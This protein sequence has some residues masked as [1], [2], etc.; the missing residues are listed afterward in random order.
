MPDAVSLPEETQCGE[1]N[2]VV[3]P[4]P[5][6]LMQTPEQRARQQIEA[7]LRAA[8]WTIQDVSA[9]NLTAGRGIAVREFPL[10]RGHGFA[11]YLL[12]GDRKALGTIEAK[13]EGDTLTGVEVQSEKYATGLPTGV[14]AWQ[15]PLSFLYQSTGVETRFTNA[16]DPDPRSREVFTFHQPETLIAWA[17]GLS[18]VAVAGDAVRELPPPAYGGASTL[19]RRLRQMP[20][21]DT[22][23]MRPA[24]ITA[25]R[26]LERSL[27]EN[28]PRA[29]V[30]MATGAG[31]TYTAVALLY[32]LVKY[33][34]ARRVLFLVDR[35]NLARQTLRE[36][37][38]Y[39]TPDDGRKFAELYNIQHLQASRIDPVSRVCITT[40]QRLYS[41]L[42]GEELDP[43]AEE[44]SVA[45]AVPAL[46]KEPLPVVYNS[47][48]P[49]ETFDFIIT[50][51]CHRSIYNLWR[52]V[53]EYFDGYLIG[54]TATPS[55][56][57]FG[58][59]N[60]NLV[61]EYGHAQAVADGVNV[62]FD[63]YRIQTR[64]TEQG[65][66]VEAGLVVDRRDRRS[67]RVRWEEL[68]EDL[69]YTPNQLDNAVVAEDQIRTVIR[70][71][72]DRLFT[73]IFPGR[74]DVPKTLIFA[75]DDSHADD[76]VR[77][78][79]EEFGKGN[80]FCE[81]ITYR[82]STIRVVDPQTGA[83][84]YRRTAGATPEEHLSAF[85]NSYNPRIAV[86]VDMIA[87]GTDVKPLEIVFFMRDVKSANY[88]EQMKGRG[89]RTIPSDD[90]L[91]VTPDAPAKVRFVIVDA[92][93]VTERERKDEPPLERQP[94]VP[95][96]SL[97]QAVGMGNAEPDVVSTLASR[98]ARLD[99]R[100][101]DTQRQS[102]VE[103]MGTSLT[104]LTRRLVEA[105]D[106]DVI[107]EAAC[108][109]FDVEEPAPEQIA[110]VSE[111]E[112]GMALAPFQ[113]P[114]LRQRLLDVQADLE[115]TIDRVSQDEVLFAGA[116]E[117][118]RER[119]RQVTGS[120]ADYLREHRDEITA[121]QLLYSRPKGRGPTL[122]QLKELAQL[123]GRPPHHWTPDAL[124]TAYETLEKSR[125][126]GSG[127]RMVT[128]LVSLVRF[129]LEQE[130]ILAPF[131]ETVQ[132]RFARW[133]SAQESA[134]RTFTPEQREW[135]EMIR[136]HIAAS[137][138][139]DAD[140]FEYVPFSERGGLGKAYALFG[141]RLTPLLDE[142]NEVLA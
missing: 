77:I 117:S 87:T 66:K 10:S 141:D 57:T 5:L 81:K 121:I 72:R 59:F 56:Q 16:L 85:R 26:N 95:F 44:V 58:F 109:W 67:R 64:I 83:V 105:V 90:L 88:F 103:W 133:L 79:R 3:T 129:A 7:Q 42:K 125:V 20:P 73:E 106:P 96:R 118:A 38:Q 6:E 61:M 13:K 53:L 47:Q 45:D 82:T 136:D 71:F 132:D 63:V 92:I 101:S 112:R 46:G 52:Q 30:Q 80:E 130:T 139:V 137:L 99:R 54:L 69:T 131:A 107:E 35:S 11:D 4:A 9:M 17:Q 2:C 119:A 93:G 19:L 89:S 68:E 62:D 34:G 108:R 86:T 74:T 127:R 37:Q 120:F 65:A 123:I 50:D 39:T 24:Q 27:A 84:S 15:R 43:A 48:V 55:K 110:W 23:G 70:T 25:I 126:R 21:L 32:R 142:L 12:Y 31:K 36:F 115:Q 116:S 128:D 22:E 111:R 60:Q 29:L 1:H 98:L 78:V 33:A 49:I 138:T 140:D 51:E 75:K 28:R 104:N 114:E 76:I 91:T 135:L 97:L 100:L 40:I 102:L 124:W 134:G 18:G 8:G 41:I 113:N 94:S 14:P 122:K